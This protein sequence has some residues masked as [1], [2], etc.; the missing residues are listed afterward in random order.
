MENTN[1]KENKIIAHVPVET[2]GFVELQ[3][4]ADEKQEVVALKYLIMKQTFERVKKELEK[5]APPF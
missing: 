1:N 5:D 2:Y 3:F 4:D